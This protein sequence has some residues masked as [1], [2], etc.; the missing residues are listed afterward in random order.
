[1]LHTTTT[2][3]PADAS[4]RSRIINLTFLECLRTEMDARCNDHKLVW[5][6]LPPLSSGAVAVLGAVR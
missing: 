3:A 1:M 2:P 4:A 5:T 6:R